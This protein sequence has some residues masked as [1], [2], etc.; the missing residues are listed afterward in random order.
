[1]QYYLGIH[2]RMDLV[3][4]LNLLRVVYMLQ[5]SLPQCNQQQQ[6]LTTFFLFNVA[7]DVHN[8]THFICWVEICL[9]EKCLWSLTQRLGF[10]RKSTILSYKKVFW[11]LH[12]STQFSVQISIN[13]LSSWGQVQMAPL[14]SNLL[15]KPDNKVPS[16]GINYNHPYK[17]RGDLERT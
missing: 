11:L 17:E 9:L 1:M 6:P 8:R 5:N 2:A 16:N 10:C 12:K 15:R 4:Y 3:Y 7:D 14:A 13:R